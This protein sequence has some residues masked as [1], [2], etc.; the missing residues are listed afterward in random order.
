MAD[1]CKRY[2]MEVEIQENGLIRDPFGW[3]MGRCDEEWLK[4][5]TTHNHDDAQCDNCNDALGDAYD[6][7][8]ERGYEKGRGSID[9]R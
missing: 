6:L 8:F 2:K 5:M 3:V 7:G 1:Y 9:G 4:L